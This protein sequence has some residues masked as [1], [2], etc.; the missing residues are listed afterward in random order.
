M[1]KV[2]LLT[3][4]LLALTVTAA[5]AGG[6]NFNWGTA[7]YTEAPVSAITFACN[8]NGGSWHMVSSF[9]TD[10]EVTDFVGFELTMVGQTAL[11]AVPDWWKLGAAPDCRGSKGQ[12]SANFSA[13]AQV[14]CFDWG[15]GQAVAAYIPSS[16]SYPT[17]NTVSI[18][19][20]AAIG[21]DVPFDCLPGTEY[22]AGDFL[23]L[24]SKAVGTG[25]CTGC[26]AG[27]YWCVPL[28]TAAGLSG[29]RG[30]LTAPMPGGNNC[31]NWNNYIVPTR[32]TTWGQV[33]SLYR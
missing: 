11:A 21:P 14:S 9:K 5:L 24:N 12:F 26:S 15:G 16:Y 10:V 19:T 28:I 29:L 32:N 4:V 1:K 2:L 22:Y 6:V 20:G 25:A 18:L 31:L 30:D 8:T 7:C 17:A 13:A 23:I 33:K 27:M 3:S